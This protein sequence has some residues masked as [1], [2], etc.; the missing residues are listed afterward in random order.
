MRTSIK[1]S[2]LLR[3][4]EFSIY[5]SLLGLTPQNTTDWVASTTESIFFFFSFGGQKSKIK[6]P[7]MFS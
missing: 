2:N 1:L 3:F 7:A 5:V 4:K 6:V